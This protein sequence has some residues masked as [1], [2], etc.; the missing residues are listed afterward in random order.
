MKTH[1]NHR[2]KVSDKGPP[3]EIY[4]SSGM[5]CS[6]APRKFVVCFSP[7]LSPARPFFL[8]YSSIV[9]ISLFLVERTTDEN[10]N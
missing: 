1:S 5:P 10:P 9:Q 4:S 6:L 8:G 3:N 2:Q 7:S